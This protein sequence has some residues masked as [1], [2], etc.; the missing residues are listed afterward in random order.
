MSRSH[1]ITS[2][3]KL[4]LVARDRLAKQILPSFCLLKNAFCSHGTDSL[5]RWTNV[6]TDGKGKRACSSSAA[7]IYTEIMIGGAVRLE[8]SAGDFRHDGLS[9]RLV[10]L[11]SIADTSARVATFSVAEMRNSSRAEPLNQD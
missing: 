8:I 4:G 3:G 11:L 9:S 5:S 6:G 1:R 2:V 7:E 10:R